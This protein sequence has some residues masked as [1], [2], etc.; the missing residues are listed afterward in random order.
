MLP[1]LQQQSPIV[2]IL[3]DEP[4]VRRALKLLLERSGYQVFTASSFDNFKETMTDCD[5]VLCDIVLRG[6]DGLQ[7]LKWSREN[8]SNTPVIM[9]TG[10][11]NYQTAAVATR[12]GAFDYLA[13]P[14]QNAD[15]LLALKRAVEHRHLLKE[16]EHLVAENEIYRQHLEQ[17]VAL[18]MAALRQ[19]QEFL[20][21]LTNTMADAVFSL[22]LPGYH[23]DYVNQAASKIFGYQVD[24]LL[25]QPFSILCLD[26]NS[27]NIFNRK[28]TAA[29]AAG[30]S[31][32]RIEQPMRRKDG[33]A[34][35]TEVVSTFIYTDDGQLT[36][37][38][39]VIR[40]VTQ[41][42]FLMGMVAHELRSP[43]SLVVG[44]VN[45]MLAD[46][47]KM[48]R[49][50]IEKYLGVVNKHTSHMLT[51]LDEL[52]DVTKIEFGEVS[53]NLEA[54]DLVDLLR[55]YKADYIYVA[56]KKEIS[57]VETYL[58]KTLIC[59]CDPIKIGEVIS[60]FIDNAI[61]YSNP[62]TRVK[63]IARQLDD[64]VWVGIED[65]GIG[66]KPK[67][68][69][70]VFTGFS[71][72]KISSK[73]TAGESSTGLGLI[74]CKRIIEAHGGKIGVESNPKVGTTFWFSLPLENDD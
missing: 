30:H 53:L 4:G 45:V 35:P 17:Q 9:M 62:N 14:V 70:H 21:T 42:S 48:G 59:C 49:E 63:I 20:S 1:G 66:I 44:F 58:S 65:W 68:M 74:I 23:M 24:E 52:L 22:S 5:V 11:P 46:I 31:Q 19:S 56:Q 39:S 2:V 40:D 7:A 50:D 71:H 8:Y 37:M 33:S 12:F 41:R 25:G 3:D 38:I 60:N 16:K 36:E 32:M 55:T 61:K 26:K 54:V 57:F 51:I 73:P 15:L 10:K 6:D 28:Q 18:Q 34:V 72:K 67:E 69:K 27:F 13:K 47:S 43:L 64:S 29:I